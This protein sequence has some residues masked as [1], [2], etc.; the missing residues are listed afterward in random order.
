MATF[1]RVIP[2]LTYQD[3]AAA[4]DFLVRAFGFGSG[5]VHRTPDGQAVHGEVRAGD[6]VIW[7]HRVTAE[8]HLDS[9]AAVDMANSGLVVQVDDVDAHYQ[10][11]RAAGA[12]IDS[13]PVDQPYGQRE[14]GAR[15]P[16]GHRWWFTTP[17]KIS[18][19]P[20]HARG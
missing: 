2:L 10:H 6:A 16:E 9:P 19:L 11:A 12:R 4:H 5:G 18:S 7:L 3:I 17:V 14:Y 20:E 1:E 8:H 13:E 15:D